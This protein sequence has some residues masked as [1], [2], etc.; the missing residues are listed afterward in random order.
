MTSELPVVPW[1]TK[2]FH[3]E[4]RTKGTLSEMQFRREKKVMSNILC[5]DFMFSSCYLCCSKNRGSQAQIKRGKKL[6]WQAHLKL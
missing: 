6:K 1:R 4:R 3:F 2:P 5:I